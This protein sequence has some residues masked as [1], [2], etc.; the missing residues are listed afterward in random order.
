MKIT[1]KPKTNLMI[2]FEATDDV[3][4][5]KQMSKIQE[6]TLQSCGKCQCD[7]TVYQTRIVGKYT[8]HELVCTK[9]K[10]SLS[11]GKGE[12]GLYPR[13]YEMDEE[14]PTKPKLIDG[15]KV[16]LPNNGWGK[17]NQDTQQRE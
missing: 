12:N 16:W 15:K 11:F 8:Y 9:C 6:L 10:A 4:F 5:V 14:D 17:W 13:R 7:E 3:D 2:E 1:Y